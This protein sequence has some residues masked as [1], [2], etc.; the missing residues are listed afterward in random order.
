MLVEAIDRIQ[1]DKLASQIIC[2]S[3]T[4]GNEVEFF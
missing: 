3:I 1:F 4:G 2:S